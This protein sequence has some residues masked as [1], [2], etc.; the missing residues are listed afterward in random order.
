MRASSLSPPTACTSGASAPIETLI[1]PL[2]G[3]GIATLRA[4]ARDMQIPASRR[5]PEIVHQARVAVRRMRTALHVF[6]KPLVRHAATRLLRRA[7]RALG[8]IGRAL[9]D[10]RDWDVIVLTLLPAQ[11]PALARLSGDSALRRVRQVAQLAR[12]RANTAARRFVAGDEFEALLE[13]V[14]ELERALSRSIVALD[15]AAVRRA[16][17]RQSV[18]VLRLGGRLAQLGRR[19][20]HRLRIEAK[21]LRYAVELCAPLHSARGRKQWINALK[22]LQAVLGTITDARALADRVGALGGDREIGARLQISARESVRRQLPQAAA[23]FMAWRLAKAPWK[24]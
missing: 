19:E 22:G 12:A 17:S 7:D 14:E 2:F 10:A 6:Q 15:P 5:D 8:R 4:A 3:A 20:R 24:A 16:L 11:A 21:R 1:A 9:G 13:R 23:L 18:A